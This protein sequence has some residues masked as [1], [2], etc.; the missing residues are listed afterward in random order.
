MKSASS[1][2][3]VP[4]AIIGGGIAGIAAAVALCKL[5][6]SPILIEKKPQLGGR[7]RSVYIRSIG[8]WVD[9]GQHALGG[10]YRYTLELLRTLNTEQFIHFENNLKIDFYYRTRP[11][12]HFQTCTAP[13][14]L[15]FLLPLLKNRTFSFSHKRQFLEQATRFFLL[16]GKGVVGDHFSTE[17]PLYQTILEPL[18]LAA[19][20]TPPLQASALLLRN[21]LREGF[22]TTRKGTRLGIPQRMLQFI[23]GNPAREWLE[24]HGATVLLSTVVTSLKPEKEFFGIA[25]K[26]R[27]PLQARAVI[28]TLPPWD[29]QRLA[30]QSALGFPSQIQKFLD[31]ASSSP[32][33][34]TTIWFK[35]PLPVSSVVAFP[36]GPFQWMFPLPAES[37]PGNTGYALVVSAPPDHL[38]RQN[39]HQLNHIALKQLQEQIGI[40]PSRLQVTAFFTMKER[41]ATLL[42]TPEVH[43]L[44]PGVYSGIP[45]LLLAGDWVQTRLPA[46]LEGAVRSAFQAVNILAPLL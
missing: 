7:A 23:L 39:R 17:N 5:G 11:P 32:I 3:T 1:T 4:V 10:T 44:R 20:N 35:E 24:R 36:E 42:Q 14:P 43:S 30:H 28:I 40:A 46:T 16:P 26:N 15:H 41:R 6:I 19:L 13:P 33:L 8:A 34:T 29:F 31:T 9:N 2:S 37:Y 22:L 27:P 25:F 45:R 38:L 18:T 12:F 21:V